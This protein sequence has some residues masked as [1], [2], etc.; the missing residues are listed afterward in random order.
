MRLLVVSG[1]VIDGTITPRLME[2]I[3]PG[4]IDKRRAEAGTLPT[5][6]EFARAIV[7]ASADPGLVSGATVYVGAVE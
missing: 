5:V 1:D 3:E 6:D 2:R 7:D 4:I